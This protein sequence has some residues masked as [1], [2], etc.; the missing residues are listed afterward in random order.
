[1]E[2]SKA[3]TLKPGDRVYVPG[4]KT[5]GHEREGYWGRVGAVV[6]V[7]NQQPLTDRYGR[8]Y[9]FILVEPELPAVGRKPLYL[10]TTEIT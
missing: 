10:R 5:R 3:L 8:E 7:K 2:L 1:M 4:C 6:N 9:H